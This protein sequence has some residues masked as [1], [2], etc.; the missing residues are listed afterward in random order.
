MCVYYIFHFS[1]LPIS[2]LKGRWH[3]RLSGSCLFSSTH[4]IFSTGFYEPIFC[5]PGRGRRRG[6]GRGGRR[7]WVV[8]S[9]QVDDAHGGRGGGEGRC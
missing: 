5:R 7:S 6:R 1:S 3:H 9:N 4:C 8:N 2:T